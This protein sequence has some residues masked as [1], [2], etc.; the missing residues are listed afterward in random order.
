MCLT[1]ISCQSRKNTFPIKRH[2]ESKINLINKF[3][4]VYKKDIYLKT[5]FLKMFIPEI[6]LFSGRIV[7]Q[8]FKTRISCVLLKKNI[9][10]T[11]NSFKTKTSTHLRNYHDFSWYISKGEATT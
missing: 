8:W 10:F 5:T 1:L 11:F 7:A 3:L 4:A 9:K 6:A 2:S